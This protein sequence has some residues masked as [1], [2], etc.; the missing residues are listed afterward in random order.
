MGNPRKYIGLATTPH[1]PAIA[2]VDSVGQ[3][4]FAEASERYLQDKRAWFGCPAS[5]LW[6]ERILAD[7]TEP[8]DELVGAVSWNRARLNEL[9][10]TTSNQGSIGWTDILQAT[11]SSLAAARVAEVELAEVRDFDHYE[12]HAATGCFTS[13][14]RTAACAVIDGYGEGVTTGFFVF[15]NGRLRRLDSPNDSVSLGIIYAKLTSLCGWDWRKGEEWKVMG[16]ASYGRVDPD[17]YELFRS[18]I[19]VDGLSLQMAPDALAFGTATG[20]YR[21]R[22]GQPAI[23]V[24]DLAHT[25]QRVFCDIASELL[26][27][28]HR[29]TGL[30]NLVLTGG[31]A[32]NSSW[33]GQIIEA[34]PFKALHVYA[35][36][37][38]DGNAV[39]AA[40]L[41]Y[42]ADHGS[43]AT[44]TEPAT[45]YLGSELS[46]TS[47][48]HLRR[49]SGLPHRELSDAELYEEIAA[50]LARGKLVGWV[51]GRAE[52]G[53]RA[54]GNRSILAD[55]RPADIKDTINERVKFREEFRPFA[56]S[57]LDAHGPEYFENYQTSPYMER[58]LRF[59]PEVQSKVPGVVHVDGTGRV[60][61][62]RR[63]W[64]ERYFDLLQRFH[65][66]TG[67]PILL[68]TSFNV[69][70]KPIIATV[71]DAV[72]VFFTSGLDLLVLGNTVFE[73][74]KP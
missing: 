71:E 27:N 73:K 14:F 74:P 45:A 3:I 42:A 49:F 6:L 5:P 23:E 69:M 39:G 55:P 54:L 67:V 53:P 30:D 50:A 59:K 32:L 28:L 20:P 15:E 21:R 38:D 63:E 7:Y 62:V 64:N 52:F 56:P 29:A 37:A 35:A 1:D 68:N 43:V 46:T 33:N 4:V 10:Q 24:A 47:L 12:C 19:H 41:A 34:T 18:A 72:A 16:L 57:I 13:P 26:G 8:G 31:C 22:P 60:Q 9:A 36:P 70:G 2:I 11:E 58:T 48:T 51:Q 66:L 17:L 40:L 44:R 65:E 61:S 25:G